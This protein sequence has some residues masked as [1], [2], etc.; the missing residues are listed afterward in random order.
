[1]IAASPAPAIT[2]APVDSR[3]SAAEPMWSTWPC[4]NTIRSTPGTAAVISAPDP[5]APVSISVA[6]SPSRQTYTCQPLTRNIVRFG[7]TVSDS[8]FR[9][10]GRDH[11]CRKQIRSRRIVAPCRRGA[12]TFRGGDLPVHRHRG[13]DPS[14][15]VR[16]G[17]DAAGAWSL[18]T[19]FCARPLR[20]MAV[21]CSS[22]PVT[23]CARRSVAAVGGRRR[24]RRAAC[25][26]VAGA[27]GRRDR[28][29]G[30]TR[31]GLLRRVLNR[32]ARVMSAG[33]GGQILVDGL[34]ARCSRGVDLLAWGHGG[35]ATSPGRSRCFRSARPGCAR[36][37]R[38]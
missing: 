28:R 8:I 7:V 37:S 13:F 29:G 20:R 30:A 16:R 38:R 18:T 3:S 33:H 36:V 1:M 11:R 22:T 4:V 19:R 23:A 15:G 5:G 32:A 9:P 26:G 10:Y 27:D 14:V 2:E 24:G 21:G 25:A 12:Q 31:G 35:C 17:V 34:T 6:E